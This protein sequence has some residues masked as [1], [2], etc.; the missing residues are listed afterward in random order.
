MG[1]QTPLSLVVRYRSLFGYTRYLIATDTTESVVSLLHQV[2]RNYGSCYSFF[3]TSAVSSS[4]F[5][6]ILGMNAGLLPKRQSSAV[7]YP[8]SAPSPAE[9]ER[10]GSEAIVTE[11][12]NAIM[13]RN[14][15]NR[16]KQI[17]VESW[18][19]RWLFSFRWVDGVGWDRMGE[20]AT[21]DLSEHNVMRTAGCEVSSGRLIKNKIWSYRS[22]N[23]ATMALA[24]K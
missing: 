6:G 18:W 23:L 20:Y 22:Y 14:A 10:I 19:G 15:G 9:L 2:G 17:M 1:V 5:I 13:T 4:V 24:W 12:M 16:R 3:S 11:I 21:N 7:Q 8:N